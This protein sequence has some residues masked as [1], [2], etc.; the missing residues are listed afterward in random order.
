MQPP[1]LTLAD[2]YDALVAER[3]PFSVFNTKEGRSIDALT[4]DASAV[5]VL[6]GER[7]HRGSKGVA[8]GPVLFDEVELYHGGLHPLFEFV[9]HLHL[10]TGHCD[11][12]GGGSVS[13]GG[14]NG[15]SLCI[16]AGDGDCIYLVHIQKGLRGETLRTEAAFGKVPAVQLI[17]IGQ[18]LI[19]TK[20]ATGKALDLDAGSFLIHGPTRGSEADLVFVVRCHRCFL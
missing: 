20:G 4:G 11:F 10:R 1:G 5:D 19:A 17:H 16:L 2:F 15:K 7:G 9:Y 12:K 18:R 8:Q 13:A 14:D 3:A 6:D